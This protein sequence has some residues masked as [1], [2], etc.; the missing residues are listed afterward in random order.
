MLFCVPLSCCDCLL[1]SF[2]V[3][4]EDSPLKLISLLI[5]LL[6]LSSVFEIF[7]IC[8]S[9]FTAAVQYFRGTLKDVI[10]YFQDRQILFP[11]VQIEEP[12]KRQYLGLPK[13]VRTVFIVGDFYISRLL[14]SVLLAF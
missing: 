4:R 1:I 5:L 8:I 13:F 11:I 12:K 10:G 6:P 2:Q 7:T 14:F 3:G 9:Y